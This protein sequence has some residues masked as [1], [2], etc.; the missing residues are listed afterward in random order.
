[1]P[2]LTPEQ[3]ARRKRTSA[4][5]RAARRKKNLKRAATRTMRKVQRKKVAK[6]I[7]TPLTPAKALDALKHAQEAAI[8]AMSDPQGHDIKGLVTNQAK[9]LA[10]L[11]KGSSSKNL[12]RV[13]QAAEREASIAQAIFNID[14]AGEIPVS[15]TALTNAK[16]LWGAAVQILQQRV[17]EAPGVRP[18]KMTE[19]ERLQIPQQDPKLGAVPTHPGRAA[20]LLDSARGTLRSPSYAPRN[21]A[22]YRKRAVG[23]P[24]MS[25]LLRE[26]GMSRMIKMT[27][28]FEREQKEKGL[29]FSHIAF[30]EFVE[31][32]RHDSVMAHQHASPDQE[33]NVSRKGVPAKSSGKR[34]HAPSITKLVKGHKYFGGKVKSVKASAGVNAKF[35]ELEAT[36]QKIG[37]LQGKIHEDLRRDVVVDKEILSWDDGSDLEVPERKPLTGKQRQRL[38]KSKKRIQRRNKLSE[39]AAKLQKALRGQSFVVELDDGKLYRVNAGAL[40]AMATHKA[41]IDEVARGKLNISAPGDT[42]TDRVGITQYRGPSQETHEDAGVSHIAPGIGPVRQ[43]VEYRQATHKQLAAEQA[44]VEQQQA[45][46]HVE[47]IDQAFKDSLERRRFRKASAS[48]KKSATSRKRKKAGWVRTSPGSKYKWKRKTSKGNWSYRE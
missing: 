20:E 45:A 27:E 47:H 16:K 7:P 14:D 33:F 34:V 12:R 15:I 4:S 21:F 18:S 36:V 9:R 41:A 6:K 22:K 42:V 30:G 40:D 28:Q 25:K 17:K 5:A 29:P 1:M 2:K 46:A 23:A 13:V 19:E 43:T 31:D 8:A 3:Q 24:N 32:H 38:A 48:A 26:F 44:L 35:R 11:S 37:T 39:K 10:L